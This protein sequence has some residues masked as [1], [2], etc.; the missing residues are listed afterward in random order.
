MHE[1]TIT[2]LNGT[3]LPAE[4]A[5]LPVRDRGFRFGDGVF[6]TIRLSHGVPYQW[7]LHLARLQAGLQALRITPPAVD[8]RVAVRAVIHA[9]GAREG[10]LRL[11]VSRGMGSQGYLPEAGITAHWVIEY[12]PPVAP[13][14][15]PLTLWHSSITRP[16]CSA[17][18]VN[19]KIAHGIGSTLA[20]MEARDHGCD[21]AI[22][23]T[24]E[25]WIAEAASANI[26]WVAGE[27]L[28]TPALRT[29]CL[30]GTTRAAIMRLSPVAV[31]EVE[32]APTALHGA[33]AIF[34]SNARL[35][36]WHARLSTP[37]A[38]CAPHPLVKAIA[39]RVTAD[40][41]QDAATH[42]DLWV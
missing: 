11:A 9:N 3:L 12:L 39:T 26:F 22:L 7:A 18:P 40:Y 13:P 28:F 21:E 17:L 35:G 1:K 29:G 25:G 37:H 32:A 36:V 4:D 23:L 42:R 31:E 2:S 30:A 5:L 8:W 19:H 15:Q 20:L 6:E 24:P 33:E 34:L 16:P 27:A 41:A 38:P 10:F 14:S